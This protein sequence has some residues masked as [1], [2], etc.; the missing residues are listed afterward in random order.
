MKQFSNV[1]C[2]AGADQQT[3]EVTA[4]LDL[5]D[6]YSH[7]CLIETATGEILEETRVRTDP[8]MLKRRF[9]KTE[10]V[11]IAIETGTHS[12]WVS[13]LLED[14][15]HEVLVANARELGFIYKN[16]RKNDRLDAENLARVA[17]LDPKLLSPIEHRGEEAQ[18]ALALLRTRDVLVKSR[19]QF[20]N[21]LRGSVKSF[22]AR[23]PS[24]STESFH[25]QAVEALPDA[26][27]PALMP[28]IS[29][30]ASLTD[31]IKD[32]DKQINQV[33]AEKYPETETLRQISGVGAITALAFVLVL[34]DPQRFAKSRQVGAFLGMVPGR[35]QSGESDPQQRIT[36][37]G[38]GML[39]WLLV[40]CAHYI[41]RPNS[42]DSDLKRFGLKLEARGGKGAKQRAV[43]AVARKLS[44]LLH[45]LWFTGEVYEPLY[46]AKHYQS[47][48]PLAA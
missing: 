10:P 11:R 2:V 20:I 7:L 3:F 19:T 26:L 15:G 18:A 23:L 22:G 45:H 4:G 25:R 12:P 33:A 30:I 16:S 6:K 39:R 21:H 32:F 5:G 47:Q 48:Q 34:E 31:Q 27:K 1:P 42:P 40:Q 8:E 37:E 38:D 44:V 9:S 28:I 35:N 43:V 24:C 36:K 14:A 17:R 29:T 13:R 46:N 41:L